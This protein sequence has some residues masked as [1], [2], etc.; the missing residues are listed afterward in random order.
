MRLVYCQSTYPGYVPG[1]SDSPRTDVKWVDDRTGHNSLSP[2]ATGQGGVIALSYPGH[3]SH[4]VRPRYIGQ[5]DCNLAKLSW[6]VEGT[7]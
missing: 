5:C 2:Q 1:G 3:S 6:E 4:E 7:K